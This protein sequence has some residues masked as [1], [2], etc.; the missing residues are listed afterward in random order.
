MTRK[1]RRRAII[2]KTLSILLT[3]APLITYVIMGL[4][5]NT[6]HRGDKLFLGGMVICALILVTI[7]TLF[8]YHLRSPLFLMLLGV[9][10]ALGNILPLIIILS[11]GVVLDEFILSPLATKYKTLTTINKEIDKRE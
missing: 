6:I 1:Y 11:I 9:Y 8:K 2:C 4:I 3:V 7:N 10:F 5:D